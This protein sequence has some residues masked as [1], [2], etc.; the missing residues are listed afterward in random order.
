MEM[1]NWQ[2]LTR[3]DLPERETNVSKKFLNVFIFLGT[4]TF[5]FLTGKKKKKNSIVF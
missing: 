3:V 2:K 4:T 5:S 1:G